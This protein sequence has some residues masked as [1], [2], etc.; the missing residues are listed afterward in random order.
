[1]TQEEIIRRAWEAL[2]EEAARPPQEGFQRLVD[3]GIIDENG[4]VI[5]VSSETQI[6]RE[7]EKKC[8]AEEMK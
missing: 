6:K 4:E 1:M 2:R 8:E 3:A 7:A 5:F